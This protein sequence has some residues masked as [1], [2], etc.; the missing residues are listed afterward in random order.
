MFNVKHWC[1]GKGTWIPHGS[2]EYKQYELRRNFGYR[3]PPN[4]NPWLIAAKVAKAAFDWAT[5]DSFLYKCDRCGM[6]F[7]KIN[8]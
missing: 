6:C 1:G 2:E 8:W 5:S 4:P 7:R 3:I